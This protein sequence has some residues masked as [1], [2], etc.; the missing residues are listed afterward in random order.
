MKAPFISG[1]EFSFT[2]SNIIDRAGNKNDHTVQTNYT[3]NVAYLAD[4]DFDGEIGVSDLN[5][6]VTGWN[7][8]DLAFEINNGKT[9]KLNCKKNNLS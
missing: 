7:N 9:V 2:F 6:F 3:L 8:K 4:F 1:D 5:Q